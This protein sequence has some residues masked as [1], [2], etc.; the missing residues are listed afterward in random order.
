MLE[1]TCASTP[2]LFKTA[3]AVVVPAGILSPFIRQSVHEANVLPSILP[4]SI[5][6]MTLDCSSPGSMAI[7][8]PG[9]ISV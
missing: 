3:S 8:L 9:V 7:F 6:C 4:Q 5:A 1:L 2:K